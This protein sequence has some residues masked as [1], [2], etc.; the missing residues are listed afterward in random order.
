MNLRSFCAVA[1]LVVSVSAFSQTPTGVFQ[2]PTL[3]AKLTL[4]PDATFRWDTKASVST[5]KF[6]R[7]GGEVHLEFLRVDG[8]PVVPGSQTLRLALDL[9]K[10]TAKPLL[11]S[12]VKAEP[13]AEAHPLAGEW[14]L[15][16]EA[17]EE[18]KSVVLTI[19]PD[20]KF[21]FRG[22]GFRSEGS[23]THEDA[24]VVFRYARIDGQNVAEGSVQLRVPM[25]KP[26]EGIRIEGRTYRRKA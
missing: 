18:L 15:E 14:V 19:G 17:S 13:V 22:S 25:A 11:P 3:Q 10:R 1:L 8:Q 23:V 7:E 20:G 12:P 21:V 26:E 16:G 4:R 24:H 6:A 9:A 2:V 5:G